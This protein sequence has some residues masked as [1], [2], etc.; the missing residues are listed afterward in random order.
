MEV[1]DEESAEGKI[2]RVLRVL[3]RLLGVSHELSRRNRRARM[4]FAHVAPSIAILAQGRFSSGRQTGPCF[5]ALCLIAS[6]S[7][8]RAR[9]VPPRFSPFVLGLRLRSLC[10]EPGGTQPSF[11]GS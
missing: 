10:A 7:P 9:R 3:V 5:R 4:I 11:D 2:P 8:T 1:A 6:H